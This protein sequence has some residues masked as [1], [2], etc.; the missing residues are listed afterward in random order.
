MAR[1]VDQ[2]TLHLTAG[3]G[4]NGCASIHREK[5]KRWAG[6]TGAMAGMAGTLF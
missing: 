6:P 3:D 4:G 1:F 2:V 5:F